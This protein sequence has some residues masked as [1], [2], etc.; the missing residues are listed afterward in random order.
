M[1]AATGGTTLL[2]REANPGSRVIAYEP[3]PGNLQ[4]LESAVSGDPMVTVRPVAVSDF[5]GSGTFFVP[6]IIDGQQKRWA[7]V[8]G[9]SRVGKLNPFPFRKAVAKLRVPVIML[10]REIQ[11]HVRFLKI[12]VQVGEFHVLNGAQRLMRQHGVDLIYVEFRG[13]LRLLRLLH[14]HGYTII[15]CAYMAWPHR[16]Y[17][18]TFRSE[19]D[20]IC[21][22]A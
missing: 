20:R 11:E 1:G 12:D 17:V 15:D 4:Y 2:A 10:E 22:G 9:S 7:G 13:D 14:R 6:S 5:E 21:N 16:R 3:F 18:S 8:A 19:F